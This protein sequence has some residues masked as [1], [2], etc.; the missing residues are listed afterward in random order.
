[1]E[2]AP[3]HDL[4]QAVLRSTAAVVAAAGIRPSA[5][6]CWTVRRGS[7]LDVHLGVPRVVERHVRRALAVRV[8]DA[9]GAS[10][11][12]FGNVDVHIEGP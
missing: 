3:I 1:M 8:L 5:T 7:D 2:L 12:R 6:H 10:G 4:E 11:Q 9:V